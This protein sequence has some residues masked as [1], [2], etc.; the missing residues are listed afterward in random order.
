MWEAG[1]VNDPAEVPQYKELGERNLALKNSQRTYKHQIMKE[2]RE[3]GEVDAQIYA[4]IKA[5]MSV[6]KK[7]EVQPRAFPSAAAEIPK[8]ANALKVG[9]PLYT[10]SAMNYGDVKPAQADIPTKFF[11]RPEAFT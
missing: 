11:P 6:A 3:N 2:M 1:M 9:N 10:T 8:P 7:Q 5:D 4:K